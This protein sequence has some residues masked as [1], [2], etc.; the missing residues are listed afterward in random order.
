MRRDELYLSDVVAATHDAP[1]LRQQIAHILAEE[2]SNPGS[3]E[4]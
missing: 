3:A 1:L 4:S 2:F